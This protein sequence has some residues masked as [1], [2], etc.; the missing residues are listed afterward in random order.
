ME[1][2]VRERERE[3][4]VRGTETARGLRDRTGRTCV[5]DLFFLLR[6]CFVFV[7]S[8]TPLSTLAFYHFVSVGT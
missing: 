8:S 5:N 2:T 7:H 3:R 1:M 6:D 4:Q